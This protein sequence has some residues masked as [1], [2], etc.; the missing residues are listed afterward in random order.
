MCYNGLKRSSV[1]FA[2]KA[3]MNSSHSY[4]DKNAMLSTALDDLHL[5]YSICADISRLINKI[6]SGYN[7][8][9]DEELYYSAIRKI[10]SDNK[11]ELKDAISILTDI[12]DYSDAK[13]KRI[14]AQEKLDDIIQIEKE[15]KILARE[16]AAEKRN[17][18][19]NVIKIIGIIVAVLLVAF[20]IVKIINS[21]VITPKKQYEQAVINIENKNY[22][23]AISIL[24]LLGSYKDSSELLEKV[25][26]ELDRETLI[27]A[28]I[29]DTVYFGSYVQMQRSSDKEK[30]EWIVLDESDGCILLITKFGI[31]SKAYNT[32]NVGI[33]WDRS[34]I[35]EWLNTEFLSIAFDE[36][37]IKAIKETNLS[38]PDND[39]FGTP[40]G[41]DTV[42]KVFLLSVDEAHQYFKYVGNRVPITQY[43]KNLRKDSWYVV[44]SDSEGKA[45]WLLRSPGREPDLVSQ[46]TTCGVT[47]SANYGHGCGINE[48]LAIRPAIWIDRNLIN[49]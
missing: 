23:E 34:P 26:A 32:E 27:N 13:E 35:R 16:A 1:E 48:Q 18:I 37:E 21:T 19:F 43:V 45:D 4:V 22:N 15:N 39:E 10:K 14:I 49:N 46:V 24:E 40:G 9:S 44:I 29:G 28:N 31:E 6:L 12:A 11:D 17:K 30:L 41:E 8:P 25:R 2:T 36:D 3:I 7:P 33:T 20:L 38:N 42:D 5:K 47:N